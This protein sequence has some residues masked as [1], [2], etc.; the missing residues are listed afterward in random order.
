MAAGFIWSQRIRE[1][2]RTDRFVL[3]QQPILNLESGEVDRCEL[4][5]R[6]LD[7]QTGGL[8][9]PAAFIEIAEQFG[10]MQEIDK[11]VVR[12][13]IE[14]IAAQRRRGRSVHAEVNLSGPSMTDDGVVAFIDEEIRAAAIDPRSLIFEVTETAAIVNIER[15][16]RFAEQLAKLGCAFALDDFGAGF[17]SF[18]YLKYLPFNYLKIDGDFVRNLINSPTDHAI[19]QAMVQIAR[20]VGVRTIAEFVED[21]RTLQALRAY[22]VDFAQGY[23]IGA[24][25]PLD[26]PQPL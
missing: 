12:R 7:E 21:E 18:Y 5:L 22:G 25:R 16:R 24:P 1:A 10:M 6:M 20:G 13:A 14:F 3:L 26:E 17:S 2:L 9:S 23:C 15:A 11:W 8:I 4:L 19:V